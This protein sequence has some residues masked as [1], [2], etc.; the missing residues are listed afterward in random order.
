MATEMSVGI[1]LNIVSLIYLT[2][3]TS[4]SSTTNIV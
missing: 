3:G 1:L 4:N 2:F